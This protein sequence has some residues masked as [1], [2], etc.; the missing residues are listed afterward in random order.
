MFRRFS[1]KVPHCEKLQLSL[2]GAEEEIV[3]AAPEEDSCQVVVVL[4]EEDNSQAV[5]V[6]GLSAT[7][8]EVAGR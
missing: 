6:L 4:A 8:L 3:V 7:L 2:V 5:V 1:F